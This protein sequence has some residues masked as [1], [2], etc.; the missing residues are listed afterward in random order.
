MPVNIE[1]KEN[2]MIAFISGELDHHTAK[3]IRAVI[4]AGIESKKPQKVFLDFS[5]VTFMDSS[6]IGLVMGRYKVMQN[7]G[8]SVII[9]NPP[10][11]IKKIMHIAGLDKN[12]NIK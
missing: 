1:F 8:G 9:A 3:S 10:S 11:H 5:G 12:A 4:D 7:I 2:E 6:G